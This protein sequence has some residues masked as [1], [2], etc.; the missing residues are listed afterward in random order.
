MSWNGRSR[1]H[2][3]KYTHY[4]THRALEPMRRKDAIAALHGE[5]CFCTPGR[6]N[7]YLAANVK[8]T[9]THI[10]YESEN[11][12]GQVITTRVPLGCVIE[13]K[14]IEDKDDE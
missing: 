3:L 13:I 7:T 1:L 9:D 10:I 12:W 4:I 2:D 11:A 14:E 6:V 5:R 8:K